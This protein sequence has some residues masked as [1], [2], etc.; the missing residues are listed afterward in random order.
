MFIVYVYKKEEEE[1]HP[2]TRPSAPLEYRS[3]GVYSQNAACTSSD[4]AFEPYIP[5]RRAREPSGQPSSVCSHC[6]PAVSS[7]SPLFQRLSPAI[8]IFAVLV[9]FFCE[10]IPLKKHP[11]MPKHHGNMLILRKVLGYV[12]DMQRVLCEIQTNL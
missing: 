7:L 10:K 3:S 8:A 12:C 9:P 11:D 4:R 5:N 6:A 1:G 2:V